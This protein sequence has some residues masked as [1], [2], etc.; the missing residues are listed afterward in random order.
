VAFLSLQASGALAATVPTGF[1]DSTFVG[2]PTDATS[3][4]FAPDGRLFICQQSGKLRIVEDGVLLGT[5]FLTLPVDST[6][7]RGLQS[8]EFDPNFPTNHFLYVYY[9]ATSPTIHN[10]VSRFTANGNVVVPGSEVVLL[11]LDT[12]SALHHMG[13]AIHFGNDGKLYIAVGD[14][15]DG[16]NAQD[17]G[18]LLGKML[19]INRDGSIPSTNPFLDRTSGARRAIWA[20]GLRNP[21]TT[22]VQRSTGRLYIN[23]VGEQTYEEIDQGKPGANYGWPT[24]EG[25]SSNPAFTNPVFAYTHVNSA[26]AITGGAFYEPETPT[27][28][29]AYRGQYFFA[30]YCAGWIRRLD[31]DTHVA[32]GFATGTL[33]P[34]DVKVGQDGALYYLERSAGRVGRISYAVSQAPVITQQPSNRTITV[35]QSVTFKVS[36]IG[37]TPL[38]FQWRRNGSPIAGAT[39]A[40]YTRTNIQLSDNGAL[41]DVIVSNGFGRATSDDA[42]LTVLQDA[43]PSA[44]ITQPVR[45]TTYAG[46]DV[47]HYAGT[48]T[49]AEDGSLPAAAFT[50]W[51][52]FHHGN[53]THPFILPFS[54]VKSGAFTIPV[55]GETAANV[56]YRIHLRVQDSAGIARTVIRDVQPRKVTVTLATNPTGLQLKLDGQPVT[57]PYSFVGV[58]GLQRKLEA[59]SPQT[60][61]GSTRVFTSWSDGG[62]RVHTISTP[63]TNRTYTARYAT[64]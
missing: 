4:N 32:A 46:G 1:V 16:D 49:D 58:V 53:H 56:F 19:R 44:A 45:G 60:A 57:A 47:I 10:R 40:T 61:S 36:A 12:L 39:G 7:E 23:D 11:E 52:D 34:V 18:T 20:I 62:A 30:D 2:V 38:S 26:C 8:V 54:G 51:I 63:A 25:T 55:G 6:G 27:F 22:A 13:G 29:A 5:P 14:N 24:A 28:P 50:W 35:G 48:A 17:F 64:Q 31:P 3:M 42:Q 41:F 43:V 33:G 15:R 59:V 9:T 37:S 21:F